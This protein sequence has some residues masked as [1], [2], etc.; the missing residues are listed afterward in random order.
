M[1]SL[2]VGKCLSVVV[3]MRGVAC[4]VRLMMPG[5]VVVSFARYQ[6]GVRQETLAIMHGR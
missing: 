4:V 5:V 6:S 3:G 2:W 1:Q